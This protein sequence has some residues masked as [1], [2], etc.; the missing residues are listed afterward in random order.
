VW[1]TRLVSYSVEDRRLFFGLTRKYCGSW[2]EFYDLLDGIE[3]SDDFLSER[4]DTVPQEREE[5]GSFADEPDLS[6]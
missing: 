6:G 3:I 4:L 5:L 2:Q 1:G